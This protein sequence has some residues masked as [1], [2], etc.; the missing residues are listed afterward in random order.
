MKTEKITDQRC[1]TTESWDM[2]YW[3]VKM[4]LVSWNLEEEAG[5]HSNWNK[6][7]ERV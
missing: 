5:L 7:T 3:T 2:E 4:K 1:L 6:R